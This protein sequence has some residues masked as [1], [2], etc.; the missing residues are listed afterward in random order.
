MAQ[1]LPRDLTPIPGGTINPA[2]AIIVDNGDGVFQGTPANVVDSGAPVNSQAEAEAGVVNTGRMSPLRVAQAIAALGVSPAVLGVEID[3]RA[4]SKSSAYGALTPSGTAAST[5]AAA[6]AILQSGGAMVSGDETNVGTAPVTNPGVDIIGEKGVYW[7][8]GVSG[9]RRLMNRPGRE[10]LTWGIENLVR[11][12][13][14]LRTGATLKVAL[15]G[16]SNTEGYAGAIIQTSLDSLPNV[17]VTNFG[18]SG[19]NIEQWRAGTAP[20]NS[21]GKA[22]SDV[23][24]YDPDLIVMC[25][26]TN[27]PLSARTAANFATSLNAALTTLRASLDIN[28][29]S[30]ALLTPNAMSSVNGQDEL[31]SLQLRSIIRASAERFT[32]G[33]FDKNGMFPNSVVDL[34]A[35]AM[36]NKFWDSNRVH[37]EVLGRNFISTK[38]VEW[39]VPHELWATTWDNIP[40]KAS[41]DLA[42]TY[43]P[44]LSIARMADGGFN[45]FVG[46][47]NPISTGGHFPLQ[48]GW[49]SGGVDSRFAWRVALGGTW[50]AW[51]FVGYDSLAVVGTLASGYSLA[52]G[53]ASLNTQR[54]GNIVNL[55]GRLSISP[56]AQVTTGTTLCNIATTSHRPIYNLQ[57][58]EVI[59]LNAGGTVER[60]RAD[61]TTAGNLVVRAT[62]AMT[63]ATSVTINENYRGA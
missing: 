44:G 34:A 36:Q 17:S 20:F 57:G 42:T 19:T 25:W 3:A 21:N 43:P 27:D 2:A 45:G 58:V 29:C 49:G 41:A 60:L 18:V 50:S 38:V 63:D 24:T 39:L 4:L 40:A 46:T 9:G 35:G 59:A 1:I 61:L 28:T 26:G 47:L 10:E 51:R 56:A 54:D 22:L 7:N 55:G 12:L 32:C 5:L 30:I 11:W 23:I 33:F 53:A 8:D 15:V 16:D 62:S 13:E 48:F 37:T 31:F 6:F 14:G 52:G